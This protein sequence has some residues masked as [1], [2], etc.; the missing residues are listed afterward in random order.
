[1]FLQGFKLN[2]FLLFFLALVVPDELQLLQPPSQ[3]EYLTF[4]FLMI[5]MFG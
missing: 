2:Q 5:V 3:G 4:S 1:M